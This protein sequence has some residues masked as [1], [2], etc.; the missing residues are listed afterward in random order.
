VPS[1]FWGREEGRDGCQHRLGEG[2]K[3]QGVK[4][5]NPALKRNRWWRKVEGELYY[6]ADFY[7]RKVGGAAGHGTGERGL[8]FDA[9][10]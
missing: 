4:R 5:H 1:L 3:K 6:L 7:E 10:Q 9:R 2:G 8:G